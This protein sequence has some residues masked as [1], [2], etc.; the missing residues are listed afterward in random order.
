MKSKTMRWARHAA[1]LGDKQNTEGTSKEID[2]EGVTR[3]DRTENWNNLWAIVNSGMDVWFYTMC[4]TSRLDE[5]L[6]DNLEVFCF[7]E[8][9][10]YVHIKETVYEFVI[11]P[12]CMCY[13]PVSVAGLSNARVCDRSPAGIVGSN[14]AEGMD[15]CCECCVLSGREFSVGLITRPEESYR[16][17]YVVLCNIETS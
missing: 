14:P 2:L 8:I 5:E 11:F 3:T 4:G 12:D 16:L 13:L 1:R 15:V 10:S 9:F 7:M 6:I 17:C